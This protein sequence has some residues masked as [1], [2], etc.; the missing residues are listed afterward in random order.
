MS[1]DHDP[2]TPRQVI[3]VAQPL[4]NE[5]GHSGL[6]DA[7]VETLTYAH[8][9]GTGGVLWR[10]GNLLVMGKGAQLPTRCVKCNAP[11]EGRPL[12]RKMYWHHPGWY[13]LILVGL[14]IYVVVALCIRKSVVVHAGLCAKHR[15]KR[16]WVILASWLIGLSFIPLG[17]VAIE[18]DQ[19]LFI[20][21]GI[22]NLLVGPII[23]IAAGQVVTPSR[24]DD[25]YAWI[26]GVCP[27]Y[28]SALPPTVPGG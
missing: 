4:Q 21:V 1:D 10:E 28:L 12:K 5:H 13:L 17:W 11:S 27:S 22:L 24:I 8:G 15:A 25:H 3:P 18:F 19:P 26:K 7:D 16:R 14:L 23:F 2:M 9:Y 6:Q 20:I